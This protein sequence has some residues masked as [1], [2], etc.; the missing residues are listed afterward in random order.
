MTENSAY[1]AHADPRDYR[2]GRLLFRRTYELC[3]PYWTR[4]GAWRSWA[5]FAFICALIVAN[6][7]SGIE[8]S[9]LTR[10]LTNALVAKHQS[11]YW[12]LFA[13][14]SGFTLIVSL[15]W[16]PMEFV[17]SRLTLHW[18]SWLTT[19][20]V[21]RYL[22]RRTYYE[23]TLDNSIDNP[24]QR[25]QEETGPVCETVSWLPRYLLMSVLNM[26][27]QAGILMSISSVLFWAVLVFAVFQSVATLKLY[28][29]TIRQNFDITVAE[30]DLRYG[31]LHVRDHAETVAFY[32]GEYAERRHIVGRL[33]NLVQKKMVYVVYSVWMSS[34]QY[35]MQ[36]VWALIPIACLV[37]LY[38]GGKIPFGV[39]AQASAAA[40]QLLAALLVVVRF[41]PSMAACAPRIV[42]L[43][44]IQEK[45]D[46]MDRSWEQRDQAS[47][48]QLHTGEGIELSR[49]CLHTPGGE[50]SLVNEL[51]L[52]VADAQHLLIVGRTGVGKSSLLRAMAG[53]WTRGTGTITMP[54]ATQM[55][56]LPQR[57]YMILGDLRSQLLYP[58]GRHDMSDADLQTIL[59]RV[60]LPKL[61]QHHGGFDA[62]KDWGRT[63]SLGEQQRIGF[64]RVLVSQPRFV[65]LDEA[66]SAVDVE[67]EGHLYDLLKSSKSTFISVGHR[68]G[69][70]RYHVRAL[71]LMP[72]GRWEIRGADSSFVD[73]GSEARRE[74]AL[75]TSVTS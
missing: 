17:D 11:A 61:A 67:T 51:T 42:R 28:Q 14:M 30:A 59:E 71:H 23:I 2:L 4:K 1:S 19:Y 38:F 72:E 10:D 25:I 70:F 31:I 55:L 47:H 13:M 64:A 32:R 12:S 26:S 27:V 60:D 15:V 5:A 50:Q 8:V 49:V 21:D 33:V 36:A 43:A 48:I 52:C 34:V 46:E 40:A 62:M 45:F 20:L 24:D 9:F 68:P 74:S 69:M 56:F 35:G 53:L 41:I 58:S 29:P 39:I 44:Q 75:I 57:P 18:R 63:L 3:K 65:F 73:G 22:Q 66:T 16:V 54:P 37:P 6:V 7:A